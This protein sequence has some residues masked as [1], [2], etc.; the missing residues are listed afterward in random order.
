MKKYQIR[1]LI[2]PVFI[3]L[4]FTL[5][6]VYEGINDFSFKN[7]DFE[8][9][10]SLVIKLIKIGFWFSGA[11]LF[12]AVVRIFFWDAIVSK[13]IKGKVPRLLIHFFSLLTYIV[14]LTIIIGYVFNK[15]LTGLWATS[16]VMAL[17]LGFALRN[18]ILDLFT[19]LAVNIERPYK[20][21]DWIE[22]KMDS[23]E[24][25]L[26]GEIIDINWR[27]TRLRTEEETVAIIPN[28][29][30]NTFIVTKYSNE[31]SKIRFETEIN[32][33]PTIEVDRVKRILEAATDKIL[34]EEPGFYETPKARVLLK[35]TNEFGLT[36]I[37]RYWINPFVGI[38]PTFARDKVNSSILNF[39]VF[40]GLR[41]SY[42]KEE[43]HFTNTFE[44]TNS[45][46]YRTQLLEQVNLFNCLEK[47]EIDELSELIK[48]KIFEKNTNIINM[49]DQGD[50]MFILGEGLLEVSVDTQN[51]INQVVGEIFPGQF[52]GEMSLLTGEPRSATITAVTD[53]VVY[54]ITKEDVVDLFKRRAS[55]LEDIS[56]IVAERRAKNTAAIESL[57]RREV[58]KNIDNFA[59]NLLNKIRH[60]FI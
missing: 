21:G 3:F 52:F 26:V 29:L 55:I 40:S 54:E 39:L 46:Q 60:F 41:P 14:A 57:S 34:K 7:P 47:D 4:I 37:V 23:I 33:D 58:E 22:I 36:Y 24:E 8:L 38:Y 56:K 16:G 35:E 6:L 5:L 10:Y 43:V 28:S 44:G 11:H 18:M 49:G 12:N 19:G 53:A 27:A 2:F 59:Q 30:L 31:N 15:P 13:A 45:K 25:N 9:I 20:I 50:S 42:P 48:Q 17:V 32:I 51:G 1:K